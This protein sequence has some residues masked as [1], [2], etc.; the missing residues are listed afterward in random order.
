MG[1]PSVLPFGPQNV[2]TTVMLAVPLGV[3]LK[4][5]RDAQR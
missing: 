5:S 4:G 2:V 1:G 3:T